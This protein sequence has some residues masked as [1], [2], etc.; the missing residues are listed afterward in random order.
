MEHYLFLGFSKNLFAAC[1][2]A[3]NRVKRATSVLLLREDSR[4]VK[5]LERGCLETLQLEELGPQQ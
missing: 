2:E 1:M 3:M 5:A 4:M